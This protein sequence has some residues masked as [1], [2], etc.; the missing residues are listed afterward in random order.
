[1]ARKRRECSAQERQELWERWKRG[2]SISDL[3][4]RRKREGVNQR[5]RPGFCVCMIRKE[6]SCPEGD[7]GRADRSAARRS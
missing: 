4:L 6:G 2:E 1:M 5:E 3:G 7:P